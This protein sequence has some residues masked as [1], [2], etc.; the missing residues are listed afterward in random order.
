LTPGGAYDPTTR[1]VQWT[2]L[3][4]MLEPGASDNVVLSIKPL[5]NLPSGTEIHNRASIRFEVFA[6][7]Q[8]DDVVNVIDGIRPSC[9]INPVPTRMASPDFDISWTGSDSVGHIRQYSVYVTEN[10]HDP[11]L[12]ARGP[13][14]STHFTGAPGTTYGFLC[15]AEDTA[16]NV[17][18]QLLIPEISTVVLPEAAQGVSFYTLPPC[19]LMDTRGGIAMGGPS[20]SSGPARTWQASGRC[21][22]PDTAVA[23]TANVTIV[24]PATNGHISLTAAGSNAGSSAPPTSFINFRK[25]QT[26]AN[27]AIISLG[28]AG[29]FAV[30]PVFV[31]TGTTDLVV[32]VA[33]YFAAPPP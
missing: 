14:T 20:L 21:G 1:T 32:D 16:G 25:G 12:L 31:P 11:T 24:Q 33:G 15:V 8:T 23:V 9:T 3:G 19:R 5:P 10:G 28:P 2:L 30:W 29:D 22:I 27:N 6:P 17:E 7:L 18:D 4:K 26:R 13:N